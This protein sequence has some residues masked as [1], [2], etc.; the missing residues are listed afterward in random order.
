[1]TEIPAWKN[2]IVRLGTMP[3]DQFLA[4]PLNPNFH[5]PEQQAMTKGSLDTLGW[6]QPVTIGKS[7]Y[8]IN[9]H[10][11]VFHALAMGDRTPVPFIELD[12]EEN[13]EHLAL[14]IIDAI[15]REAAIDRDNLADLLKTI[16][17][18]N[19]ALNALLSELATENDI[20]F[21]MPNDFGDAAPIPDDSEFTRSDVPD[22]L[23][24]S[25]N[26]YDIPLLDLTMQADAVDLPF[27]IWGS[28]KRSARMPGTWAF[29]TS[30]DRYEALW[31]DPT[32]VLNTRCVNAVE[33]NFSCYAQMP[34]AVGLWAIYRKR[35]IARYW[36][37]KGLRIFVDLN[38]NEKF[39]DLNFYGVPKGWKAYATRGYSERITQTDLEY[40]KACERA[41]TSSILFVVYGGGK[42]VKAHCQQKGYLWFDE[43]MNYG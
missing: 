34:F 6:I 12:L 18:E 10:D 16:D 13:E 1:M 11:R 7:G 5:P 28:V 2:R 43:V 8:L 31:T 24:A 21:E 37:S 38:V 9:G 36:Q 30:D 26:D 29:Y 19:E 15:V 41:G 40:D 17:T 20:A 25:D 4:N 32:P 22:A 35:W 3:A 14:A 33:P 39:Y 27:Q 23:W 42:A